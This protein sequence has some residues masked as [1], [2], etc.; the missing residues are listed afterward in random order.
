MCF[1]YLLGLLVANFMNTHG[2]LFFELISCVYCQFFVKHSGLFQSWKKKK[3]M[4]RRNLQQ[5]PNEYLWFKKTEIR[6]GDVSY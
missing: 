4:K 2:S 6:Q 5:T 3:K 1:Q